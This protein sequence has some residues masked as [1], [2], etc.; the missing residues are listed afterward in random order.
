VAIHLCGNIPRTL[1]SLEFMDIL[2]ANVRVRTYAFARM[3][4][5]VIFGVDCE[6]GRLSHGWFIII[7]ILGFSLTLQ[8]HGL[9][10]H[11][12]SGSPCKIVVSC[13]LLLFFP[14]LTCIKYPNALLLRNNLCN[15]HNILLC[16]FIF[17]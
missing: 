3:T 8:W 12:H 11:V 17:S 7:S 4:I 9:F 13:I 6:G 16:L 2:G 5:L 1:Q 15:S 14:A 10:R